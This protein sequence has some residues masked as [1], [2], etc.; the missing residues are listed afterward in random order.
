MISYN[1]H[2]PIWGRSMKREMLKTT[3]ALKLSRVDF[4]SKFEHSISNRS[5]VIIGERKF[6]RIM[7]FHNIHPSIWG[8]SMESRMLKNYTDLKL[9]RVD[10]WSK[11]QHSTSNRSH[12]IMGE[13]KFQMDGWMNKWM[14]G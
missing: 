12:V 2:P 13:K 6:Q 11:F 9:S 7:V 10:L 8:R 1:I 5:Q 4:D 14:D 3:T